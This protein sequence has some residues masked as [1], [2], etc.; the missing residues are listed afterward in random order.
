MSVNKYLAEIFGLTL[1]KVNSIESYFLSVIDYQLYLHERDIQLFISTIHKSYSVQKSQ[2]PPQILNNSLTTSSSLC[3]QSLSTLSPLS[4][5]SLSHSQPTQSAH[6]HYFQSQQQQQQLQNQ[7]NLSPW[8]SPI[9]IQYPSSSSNLH[10]NEI[11]PNTLSPLPTHINTHH[12][13][14]NNNNIHPSTNTIPNIL[15]STNSSPASICPGVGS[16]SCTNTTSSSSSS[17]SLVPT[18]PIKFNFSASSSSSSSAQQA[19]SSLSPVKK[20][21]YYMLSPSNSMRPSSSTY[22]SPNS[23]QKRLFYVTRDTEPRRD[24]RI[25]TIDNATVLQVWIESNQPLFSNSTETDIFIC[26]DSESLRISAVL[27]SNPL[28]NGHCKKNIVVFTITLEGMGKNTKH[29]KTTFLSPPP[30]MIMGA[31]PLSVSPGAIIATSPSQQQLS[32]YSSSSSNL[33]NI[34]NSNSFGSNYN[35]SQSNLNSFNSNNNN[36]N[37]NNNLN[38]NSTFV[39]FFNSVVHKLTPQNQVDNT[40]YLL[41]QSVQRA[42]S[43]YIDSIQSDI[44]YYNQVI[45]YRKNE[46]MYLPTLFLYPNV[47]KNNINNPQQQSSSSSSSSSTPVIEQQLPTISSPLSSSPPK[48]QQQQQNS[49]S[50]SASGS[51]IKF[52]S[53]PNSSTS[54]LDAKITPVLQSNIVLGGKRSSKSDMTNLISGGNTSTNNSNNSSPIIFV[55]N[56]PQPNNNN[57]SGNNIPTINIDQP[58][59]P[60]LPIP[61]Q[62]NNISNNISTSSSSSSSSSSCNSSFKQTRNVS[63]SR[64]LGEKP[65]LLIGDSS[66]NNGCAVISSLYGWDYDKKER[67]GEPFADSFCLSVDT[68]PSIKATLTIADGSGLGPDPQRASRLAVLGANEYIESLQHLEIPTT[69][70]LLTIIGNSILR[71]HNRIIE[72]EYYAN[73]EINIEP[74]GATTFCIGCLCRA[75]LP[76]PSPILSK[77]SSSSNISNYNN[78]KSNLNSTIKASSSNLRNSSVNIPNDL[79]AMQFARPLPSVP[80]SVQSKSKSTIPET[81]NNQDQLNNCNNSDN[82]SC[83]TN[84]SSSSVGNCCGGSDDSST[85]KNSIPMDIIMENYL[86]KQS[87]PEN[88]IDDGVESTSSST[89]TPPPT[90]KVEQCIPPLNINNS[91]STPTTS[92]TS[93]TITSPINKSPNISPRTTPSLTSPILLSSNS[94]FTSMSTLSSTSTII[95]NNPNPAPVSS[96][97]SSQTPAPINYQEG[98]WFFLLGSVGD[99]KAFR[100]SCSTGKVTEITSKNSVSRNFNDAGGQLGWMWGG[101]DGFWPF[102]ASEYDVNDPR[103]EVREELLRAKNEKSKPHLK[104]L[105]FGLILVSPGDRIFIT[106]DGIT[107]NFL[108]ENPGGD[109]D[110]KSSTNSKDQIEQNLT[111]FLKNQSPEVMSTCEGMSQAIVTNCI[112]KTQQ[113]RAFQEEMSRY[114]VK[115]KEIEKSHSEELSDDTQYQSYKKL[116]TK[117]SNRL[118]T[119]KHGKPDHSSIVMYEVPK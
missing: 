50:N 101:E 113:F 81:L 29:V 30:P 88:T 19:S 108:N 98:P 105:H 59:T 67:T 51:F 107:D 112:E 91:S 61:S 33:N 102:S 12:N 42:L 106:S 52:S 15:I 86:D 92:S 13:N 25:K 1:Q 14:N 5:S 110:P 57:N 74:K 75:R 47:I 58:I 70:E 2:Q 94:S 21:N 9:P 10:S 68:H 90:I 36:N 103:P 115:I 114:L 4:S 17:S 23:S 40:H 111:Q 49:N 18:S 56:N 109:N 77:L 45:S 62:N 69:N 35:S 26:L 76:T 79:K 87:P 89:S 83:S 65:N 55:N 6:L 119:I 41:T 20:I 39:S 116:Y 54:N 27:H 73:K 63:M 38:N 8:S 93:T 99:S 95:Y 104:N 82:E 16:S 3:S 32:N 24:K 48:Q 100:W 7:S 117:L 118:R 53:S 71:G 96:Q 66:D 85:F 46:G 84:S 80:A 64:E 44:L 97:P 60:P 31:S 78:S 11:T 22:I 72:D 34:N 28:M 43:N 37:S